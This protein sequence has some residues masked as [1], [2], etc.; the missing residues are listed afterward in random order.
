MG[1]LFTY[2]FDGIADKFKHELNLI[3]QQYPVEPL[4]YLRPSL[5]ITFEEGIKMLNV[6]G[7][8][9]PFMSILRCSCWWLLIYP[10]HIVVATSPPSHDQPP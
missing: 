8:R 4:K 3:A 5:R 9:I 7:G 1:G 2:I 6:S 10:R